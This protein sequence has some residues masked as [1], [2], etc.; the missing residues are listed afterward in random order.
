MGL[1]NIKEWDY[2]CISGGGD[3]YY[4]IDNVICSDNVEIEDIVVYRD[5][6]DRLYSDHFPIL[7]S[8]KL[9]K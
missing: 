4:S 8:V 5:Y 2:T 3:V 1:G 6:Y 7:Y 9:N